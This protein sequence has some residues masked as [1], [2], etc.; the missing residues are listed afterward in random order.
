[1]IR[2]MTLLL[3]LLLAGA[4]GAATPQSVS[5][6][7]TEQWTLK[8]AEGREYRIMVSL[9]EGE[10]PYTGGFPVI[11][12]LDANAYFPAFHA[13]KRAQDSLRGAILVGIGY[14]SDTPLDFERRAFDLSPPQEPERNVPPQGGQDLFLDFIEQRLMPAV[15]ARFKVDQDQRSLVGHSF[16]GMFGIYAL[17][18]RPALFQHVVAISPSLWW[19]DRY[20]LAHERDFTRRAHA[21]ELDL[22]HRSLTMW[23][24]DREMPQEIQDVRALQLR[25]QDLSQYGLRSDFQIEA[26]E[27]HMSVP[28]RVTNRVLGELLSTRRY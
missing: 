14:P 25:L 1:M 10:V 22:I 23:V 13:A 17:F 19:R 21:G 20:L 9:P 16:G 7:G 6:D 2:S 27:D 5:L 12:L 24:G 28:F 11:Y 15:D 4:A 8:S 3:C 26:G 18:T